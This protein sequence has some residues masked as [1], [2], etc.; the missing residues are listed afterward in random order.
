MTSKKHGGSSLA[1]KYVNNRLDVFETLYI[2]I[3]GVVDDESRVKI[4]IF[5]VADKFT[6]N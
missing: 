3:F 5:K 1:D 2:E 4:S 6:E